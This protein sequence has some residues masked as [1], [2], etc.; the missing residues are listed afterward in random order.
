ML[1]LIQP[2]IQIDLTLPLHA[3]SP[4]ALFENDSISSLHSPLDMFDDDAAIMYQDFIGG[5]EAV[6]VQENK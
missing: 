6:V 2:K 3:F 4:S 5:A 1:C